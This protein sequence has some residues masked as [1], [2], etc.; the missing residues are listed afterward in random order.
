MRLELGFEAGENTIDYQ[1]QVGQHEKGSDGNNEPTD[2]LARFPLYK[3][4]I[5]LIRSIVG[6]ACH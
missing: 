4:G 1:K 2:V 3:K 5:H 6:E